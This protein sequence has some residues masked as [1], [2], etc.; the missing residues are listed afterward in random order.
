[1][2]V[3][4]DEVEI[5]AAPAAVWEVLADFAAYPEWNPFVVSVEGRPVKGERLRVRIAP[6]GGRAM[7][8]TPTVLDAEPG[9]RLRWL[10]RLLL[11]GL[12]D[13]EHDFTI[14]PLGEG[15][16]RV[17]QQETFRG[18]LVPVFGKGFDR[19]LAGFRAMHAA[20]RQRV[21]TRS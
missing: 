14:E 20:L 19:T 9:R 6:P 13:G 17:V 18:P 8:F 10:G 2:R 15:R 12:F 21:E 7:T 11:P 4:R 3:L 1:M 5:D 16:S